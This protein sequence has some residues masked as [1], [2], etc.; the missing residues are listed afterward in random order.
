MKITDLM[1]CLDNVKKQHGDVT[2]LLSDTH[3]TIKAHDV[4]KIAVNSTVI[5]TAVVLSPANETHLDQT[6]FFNQQ[7]K[8][9]I[10]GN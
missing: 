9:F 7:K 4:G 5:G 3:T 8:G 10:N 6:E 2:V 1:N